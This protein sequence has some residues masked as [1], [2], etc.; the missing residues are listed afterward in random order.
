MG[1]G[2]PA[3]PFTFVAHLLAVA[4]IVM[5][6]LWNIHF[7]GGLAW[8]A[9][10]KNLIF[11]FTVYTLHIYHNIGLSVSCL[12]FHTSIYFNQLLD[13]TLN[14]ERVLL[15]GVLGAGGFDAVFAVTLGDSRSNVTKTWSSLNV[16]ALLVKEDPCGVSLESVDIRTNEITSAVS[17][18]HIE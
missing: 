7:R 9:T 14:L 18:I 5:V 16:L 13:A 12:V 3:L 17:S 1:F 2:V 8:E 4:A 15:A 11:N 6:L 10:N